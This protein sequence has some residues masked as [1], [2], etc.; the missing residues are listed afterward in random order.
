MSSISGSSPAVSRKRTV[1][2][3]LSESLIF[4]LKGCTRK[5]LANADA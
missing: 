5:L 4:G 1:N 2:L 3:T